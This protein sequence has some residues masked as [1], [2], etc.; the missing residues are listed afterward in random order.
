MGIFDWLFRGEKAINKDIARK[1][2]QR[3]DWPA[4]NNYY[5]IP[6]KIKEDEGI[7][8][9]VPNDSPWEIAI[10]ED[11]LFTNE[12]RELKK[13]KY[14]T[15]TLNNPLFL[16]QF[17]KRFKQAVEEIDSKIPQNISSINSKL[18]LTYFSPIN[19][20]G[21]C[22]EKPTLNGHLIEEDIITKEE[23][24]SMN[25]WEQIKSTLEGF[26]DIKFQ[27]DNL[28]IKK[29]W[30]IDP[31]SSVDNEWDKEFREWLLYEFRLTDYSFKDEFKVQFAYKIIQYYIDEI[32]D[33]KEL[34]KYFD[35][36]V[37][38]Q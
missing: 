18:R 28:L 17:M 33:I 14:T 21:E 30:N 31:A 36:N 12:E 27:K 20:E 34:E 7:D 5:K 15:L 35:K 29:I 37:V 10:T 13:K 3:K 11:D 24:I 23:F 16:G 8:L 2:S 25:T 32:K 6:Q 22:I 4:K 1:E 38:L 26:K 9:D 19:P